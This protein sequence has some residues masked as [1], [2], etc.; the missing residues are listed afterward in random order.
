MK[1][2]GMSN[3]R[4]YGIWRAMRHRCYNPKHA[5][6][7]NYGAKGVCVCEEWKNS[8]LAFQEWALANGYSDT[9]T[10]DRIDSH[11]GYCPENCR[12][13]T[14][15][16]QNNNTSKNVFLSYGGET[17]T[18]KQWADKTGLSANMLY[19]R[20]YRGWDIP[21]ILTTQ[22]QSKGGTPNGTQ[23]QQCSTGW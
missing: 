22:N 12:W 8:F 18:V 6:Y 2:H 10:I 11:K 23:L 17:Y 7:K 5:S 14:Y 20:L 16:E 4:L 15:K 13:A 19:K 3:T 21:K 1:K 9:L